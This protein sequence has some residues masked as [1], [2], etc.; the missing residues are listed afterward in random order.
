LIHADLRKNSRKQG[1]DLSLPVNRTR[2]L[3]TAEWASLVRWWSDRGSRQ[4]EK[5]DDWLIPAAK[6]FVPLAKKD[7]TAQE[8]QELWELVVDCGR[9]RLKVPFNEAKQRFDLQAEL[10]DNAPEKH[11]EKCKKMFLLLT[12]SEW[13]D[14]GNVTEWEREL[15]EGSAEMRRRAKI[16]E[17]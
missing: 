1:V 17:P 14:Y 16:K 8:D 10:P 3:A 12:G 11:F 15:I 6:K 7:R 5:F 2:E 9:N 13:E 4:P